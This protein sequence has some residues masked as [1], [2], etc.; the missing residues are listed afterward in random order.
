MIRVRTSHQPP[1]EAMSHLEHLDSLGTDFQLI[2][3]RPFMSMHSE[4]PGTIVHWFPEEVNNMIAQQC[5]LFPDTF[6]GVCGL[7]LVWGAPMKEALPELERCVGE[8]CMGCAMVNP[9]P[10]E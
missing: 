2:S 8:L 6:A 3:P 1:V 4:R 7:P 5:R 9:D 10:S